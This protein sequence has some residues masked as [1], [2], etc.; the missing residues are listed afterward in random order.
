MQRRTLLASASTLLVAGCA[1]MPG[2]DS[3]DESPADATP[4]P[5]QRNFSAKAQGETALVVYNDSDY[6][7][8]DNTEKVT[9]RSGNETET[10]W[11]A[12]EADA[13]QSYPLSVGNQISVNASAGETVEIVWY[14]ENST[15]GVV[16]DT[17]TVED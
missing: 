5:P 2:G 6:L 8:T 17:V 10:V 7:R 4:E 1:G 3:T 9:V 12:D 13:D 16:I 14:P 11:V 15:E